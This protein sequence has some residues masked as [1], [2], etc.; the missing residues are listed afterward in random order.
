MILFTRLTKFL[1]NMTTR[2]N[3]AV[4]VFAI[5]W[6]LSRFSLILASFA[7]AVVL[8]AVAWRYWQGKEGGLNTLLYAVLLIAMGAEGAMLFWYA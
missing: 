7:C 1:T 3:V 5:V 2:F 4:L 6:M 8:V